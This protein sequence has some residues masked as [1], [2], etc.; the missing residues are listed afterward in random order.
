MSR[1]LVL[2]LLLLSLPLGLG[3]GCSHHH[4]TSSDPGTPPA[5]T[6]N[7]TSVEIVSGRQ[8]SFTVTA[9]GE[10]TL[11]Y[12]WAKDGVNIL[13]AI[14]STYTI[15]N[16]KGSDSGSYTVTV[17]NPNGTATS[18]AATLKVD[19]A[20]PFNTPTGIAADAA[21]NLYVSDSA[22]HTIW[23]VSPTRQ[24]TLLAGGSGLPG[25]NDGLGG[26]ARFNTPGGLALDP[27]GNLLVAD[28]GNHTI[29]RIAPDGTV[30]T[31]AGTAGAPGSADG[32][33]A[34]ARFYAPSGL[35][36]NATGQVYIADSLNHTVRL[37][38]TDGTVSTYAGLAGLP[39][40]TDGA[41][42][43]AQ[44]NQPNGLALAADGTLYI[45]D[46][47]NSVIRAISP[48]GTTSLFSGKYNNRGYLDG[49]ATTAMFSQPVGL[50][51]DAASGTLYVAD[52]SNHAI[53]KVSATG[54]VSLLAGSGTL[55]NQDGQGSAGLFNLP[56]GLAVTP[57]GSLAIADTDN[58]LLR[59]V[60]SAGLVSTYLVP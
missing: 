30:T 56:C 25:S 51:L 40:Q 31:V 46:F 39:G 33:G 37:M 22:D 50:A 20:L 47:G 60:T 10:A 42:A 48:G 14:N 43:S 16:P 41:R 29:R 13:G 54:T 35:A 2:P 7:P 19:V 26:L 59:N 5:I 34:A 3:L 44:F 58:H 57:G 11:R 36:V 21:G 52:S 27:A 28:T 45:A 38:A 18:T 53:R 8:V 4:D 1:R 12:Q 55:G 32:L 49:S 15:Y 24:M 17:T 23:K 6:T 9:T